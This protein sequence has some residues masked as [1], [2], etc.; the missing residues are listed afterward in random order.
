MLIH[1]ATFDGDHFLK[2]FGD[3]HLKKHED[4]T[5]MFW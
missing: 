2:L 3:L 4:F 1:L 5:I